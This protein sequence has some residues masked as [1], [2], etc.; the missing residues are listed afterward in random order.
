MT[1]ATL[2]FSSSYFAFSANVGQSLPPSSWMN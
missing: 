2:S 1:D